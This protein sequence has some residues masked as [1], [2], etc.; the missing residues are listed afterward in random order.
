[1][2]PIE[3]EYLPGETPSAGASADARHQRDVH[4]AKLRS[5]GVQGEGNY[6]AARNFNSA[7]RRFVEQG[8]VQAAARAAA[9][10]SAAERQEMLAA[11]LVGKR[12]AKKDPEA[13]NAARK[14]GT[15]TLDK[16]G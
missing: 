5:D 10:R 1:M 15:L 4:T 6:D 14:T 9:P 13:R 12:H 16:R 8:R 7:E 2:L 3:N 11:E